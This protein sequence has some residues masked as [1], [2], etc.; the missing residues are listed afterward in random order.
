MDEFDSLLIQAT[1]LFKM[2]ARGSSYVCIWRQRA[3]YFSFLH[4]LHIHTYLSFWHISVVGIFCCLALTG[5][6]ACFL[7]LLVLRHAR[8]QLRHLWLW[9]VLLVSLA[10]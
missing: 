7:G 6:Q 2:R 5:G 9:L 1:I 3:Q 8:C 10:C 4:R